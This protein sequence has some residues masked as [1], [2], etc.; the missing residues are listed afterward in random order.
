[1]RLDSWI[2]VARM[3]RTRSQAA[4]LCKG[5]KVKLN[6]ETARPASTVREGDQVAVTVNRRVRIYRVRGFADR[7]GSATEA[8]SLFEDISPVP[9]S[10]ELAK[11]NPLASREPG[12]GRPTKK[13]R[14]A[15][16]KLR[17]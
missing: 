11:H 2:W 3:A 1:M 8:A 13:E 10:M 16:E 17:S 15:L 9:D 5:G 12:S 4:A 14:R 7:R 6:Q